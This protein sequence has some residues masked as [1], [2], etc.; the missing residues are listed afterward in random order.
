ML[1]FSK[2]QEGKIGLLDQSLSSLE[3]ESSSINQEPGGS[4]LTMWLQSLSKDVSL[5]DPWS[6]S[7]SVISQFSQEDD[8]R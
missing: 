7:F 2:R 6:T 5:F 3:G 8:K 4:T 1:I